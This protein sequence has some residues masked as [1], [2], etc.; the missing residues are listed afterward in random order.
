MPSK[1]SSPP[2]A[3][4]NCGSAVLASKPAIMAVLRN[5]LMKNQW[6]LFAAVAREGELDSPNA[7]AFI[8]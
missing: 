5:A 3:C 2:L 7:G 6:D 4:S 8:K 1:G